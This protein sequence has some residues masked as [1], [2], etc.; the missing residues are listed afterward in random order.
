MNTI[1]LKTI[2]PNIFASKSSI[3]S[4]VWQQNITFNKGQVYLINAP[5]GTG[6]SS[7][8]SFICGFRDDYN[9]R[10]LFENN[11]IRQYGSNAW[12]IIRQTELSIV[13]QDLKLFDDL[14]VLENIQIKNRLTKYKSKKEIKQY[15]E[16]FELI[17]KIDTPLKL[18]S[19]GQKQRIAI[20]RALCQPFD[21]ILLDEPI[22]HLDEI[23]S[24]KV[25]QVILEEAQ[26]Q[27]AGIIITS[28]G[29]QLELPYNIVYNL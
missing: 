10:I 15:L 11:N 14:T 21:F 19:L 12:N 6:K 28:L 5:S 4:D 22:S 24:N 2:L 1:E 27:N 29:N 3:T 18:L 9:G 16:L 25:A 13:F 8:C 26:K 7:L 23:N 17:D 20:I